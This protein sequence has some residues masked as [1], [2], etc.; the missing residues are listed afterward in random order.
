MIL[1]DGSGPSSGPP[2]G[3]DCATGVGVPAPVLSD[4]ECLEREIDSAYERLVAAQS[5]DDRDHWCRQMY[6]LI[7]RRSLDRVAEMERQRGLR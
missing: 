6:L 7:R 2:G 1:R 4:D 5:L 3:S